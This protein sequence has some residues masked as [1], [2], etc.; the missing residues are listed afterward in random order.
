MISFN[1]MP[2]LKFH[3]LEK[4]PRDLTNDLITKRC[5][6]YEH[7]DEVCEM[8]FALEHLE[9][10]TGKKVI[11]VGHSDLECVCKV[12]QKY[13]EYKIIGYST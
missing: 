4:D 10:E 12:I 2:F 13:P 5:F 1:D 3:K 9:D 11:E 8:S 6:Y 7:K